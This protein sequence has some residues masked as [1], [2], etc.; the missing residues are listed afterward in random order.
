MYFPHIASIRV[1]ETEIS[2]INTSES[3]DVSGVLRAYSHS[4]REV[5]QNLSSCPPTVGSR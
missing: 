2:V 4:G 5:L 3:K 1:W